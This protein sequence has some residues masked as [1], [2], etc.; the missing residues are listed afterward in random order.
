MGREY[1]ER[2]LDILKIAGSLC[3]VSLHTMSNTLNAGGYFPDFH[4]RVILAL[5]QLLYT[6]VPVFLLST[7]AGFMASE[8]N[9]SFGGMKRNIIKVLSCIILFGALFWGIEQVA[10]GNAL[11]LEDML[12]AILGDA[13]WSHIACWASICVYRSYR[14]L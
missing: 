6:A 11:H 3:I 12:L 4:V 13:T 5:H 8:R 9:N 14:V 10:L 1:R 7:G 2:Y